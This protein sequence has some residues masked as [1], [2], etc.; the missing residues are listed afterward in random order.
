MDS[1]AAVEIH[2]VDPN[3]RIIL[4]SQV[5]MFT[6][7]ESEV[8]RLREVLFPQFVFLDFEPTLENFFSLGPADSNVNGDFLVA[9]DT[10][11]THG[12]AGFA[13]RE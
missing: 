5:D 12:V 4:D 11:G 9:P 3:R 2:P 7:P 1:H 8:A 6:D 13:Y 10:K